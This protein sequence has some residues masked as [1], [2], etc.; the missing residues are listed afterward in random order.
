VS[1]CA[2]AKSGQGPAAVNRSSTLTPEKETSSFDQLVTQ[3]VSP[4][5]VTRGSPWMHSPVHE[6]GVSTSPSMEMLHESRLT[7]GAASA[8]RTGQL[9]LCRTA[10]EVNDQHDRQAACGRTRR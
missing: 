7:R 3:R 2:R 1:E 4:V 6:R 10:P 9:L 8:V 5:Y